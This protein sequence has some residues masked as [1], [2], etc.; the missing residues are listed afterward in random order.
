MDYGH[1]ASDKGASICERSHFEN[2]STIF[3]F[4]QVGVAYKS[5]YNTKTKRQNWTFYL[6]TT[7]IHGYIRFTGSLWCVLVSFLTYSMLKLSC[8]EV[9][10]KT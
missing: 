9:F 3:V 5:N 8:L 7:Y 2:Y 1:I 10:L 6:D 4:I